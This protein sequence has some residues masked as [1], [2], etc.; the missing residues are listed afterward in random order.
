[1]SHPIRRLHD[2]AECCAFVKQSREAIYCG[3]LAPAPLIPKLRG[4]FAEFLRE[5]SLARLGAFTPTHLCRFTVRAEWKTDGTFSR[6][7][8]Q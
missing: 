6:Q 7:L 2:F 4:Q 5:V 8:V 3:R 1:M